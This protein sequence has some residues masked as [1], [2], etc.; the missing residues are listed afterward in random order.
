MLNLFQAYKRVL[1]KAPYELRPNTVLTAFQIQQAVANDLESEGVDFPTL[2]D[3]INDA[4]HGKVASLASSPGIAPNIQIYAAGS[5]LIECGDNSKTHSNER[6]NLLIS[7]PDFQHT[8]FAEWK[9]SLNDGLA[10]IPRLS[11][12]IEPDS[13]E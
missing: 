10:V 13:D 7:F 6:Y 5:I 4:L 11:H 2:F 12:L 1:A 8:T 3:N 9:K